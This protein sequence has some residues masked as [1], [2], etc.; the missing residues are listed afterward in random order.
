MIKA[1][2]PSVAYRYSYTGA[3]PSTLLV[4]CLVDDMPLQARPCSSQVPLQISNVEYGCAVD[5]F[6]VMQQTL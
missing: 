5:M 1:N 3:Q 6:L 2:V 4:I